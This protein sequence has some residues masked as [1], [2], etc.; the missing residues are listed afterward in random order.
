MVNISLWK[1]SLTILILNGANQAI[2]VGH[3]KLNP[4]SSPDYRPAGLQKGGITLFGKWFDEAHHP[5]LVEGRGEGDFQN[6]CL[7]CYGLLSKSRE[8]RENKDDEGAKL[9]EKRREP[10]ILTVVTVF[11]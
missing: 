7:P 1:V 8:V 2:I 9:M 6:I 4:P 11:D 3:R 5:E 10:R